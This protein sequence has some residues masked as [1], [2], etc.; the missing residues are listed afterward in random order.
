MRPKN[1]TSL[2]SL[3]LKA[4]HASHSPVSFVPLISLWLLSCT[5]NI[6]RVECTDNLNTITWWTRPSRHLE[7]NPTSLE[8][9]SPPQGADEVQDAENDLSGAG[10]LPKTKDVE[11]K[12]A[13]TEKKDT[14]AEVGICCR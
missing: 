13:P 8:L 9:A 3:F 14:L 6:L 4:V 10:E 11:K 12:E 2:V 5:N 7:T 1:T